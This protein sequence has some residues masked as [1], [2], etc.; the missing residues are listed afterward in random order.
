MK[1]TGDQNTAEALVA[2]KSWAVYSAVLA[3]T[4]FS[5]QLSEEEMQRLANIN[6]GKEYSRNHNLQLV[7]NAKYSEVNNVGVYTYEIRG[8]PVL[9]GG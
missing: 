8:L 7:S 6:A 1:I 3:Q 5:Q 9:N 2:K 4:V